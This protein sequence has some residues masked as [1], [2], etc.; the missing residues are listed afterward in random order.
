MHD[1]I[2]ERYMMGSG[3][4]LGERGREKSTWKILLTGK[5]NVS[6]ERA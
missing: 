1:G 3:C 2:C 6:G 4:G 5:G